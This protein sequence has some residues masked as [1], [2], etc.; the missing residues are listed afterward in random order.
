ML[1]VLSK[2]VAKNGP[3]SPDR[4]CGISLPE[5][6]KPCENC[7]PKKNG[8]DCCSSSVHILNSSGTKTL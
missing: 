5:T 8:A 4:D 6:G 1:L 7:F 2:Y 3:P